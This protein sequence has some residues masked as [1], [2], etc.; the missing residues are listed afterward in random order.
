MV[1]S[2][3][4]KLGGGARD[5]RGRI[6]PTNATPTGLLIDRGYPQSASRPP[7]QKGRVVGT[8]VGHTRPIGRGKTPPQP[9]G[10]ENMSITPWLERVLLPGVRLAQGVLP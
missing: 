10:K 9:R 2:A 1:T 6:F 7:A 4:G 8:L 3:L 5:G